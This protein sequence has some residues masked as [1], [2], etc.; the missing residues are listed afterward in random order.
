MQ[1]TACAPDADPSASAMGTYYSCADIRIGDPTPCVA[2]TAPDAAG[3]TAPDAATEEDSGLP[4]VDQVD[5]GG[6]QTADGGSSLG[7]TSRPNLNGGD[8]GGCSIAL[9]ATSGVSFGITAGLLGLA[10]V[11]RRRRRG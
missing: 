10:L 6:G 2:P 8:G 5:G 4:Q 11:R 3:P 7:P 9:G 1:G